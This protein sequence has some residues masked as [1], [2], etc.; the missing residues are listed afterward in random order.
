MARGT[1]VSHG[2]KRHEV[3]RFVE[4][5]CAM[6]V[7]IALLTLAG[8][9]GVSAPDVEFDLPESNQG[10]EYGAPTP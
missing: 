6:L 9:G 4:S 8:C 2:G 1:A 3:V 10:P 5:C 7:L